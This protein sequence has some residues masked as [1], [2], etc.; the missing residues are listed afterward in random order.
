MS[1]LPEGKHLDIAK[2]DVRIQ[3][4]QTA[5]IFVHSRGRQIAVMR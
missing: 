3:A 4:P 5:W 1:T 2:T